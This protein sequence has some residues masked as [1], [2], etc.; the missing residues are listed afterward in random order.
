[1]LAGKQVVVKR[2]NTALAHDI[3]QLDVAVRGDG[4]ELGIGD[5]ARIAKHVRGEGAVRII[6][7]RAL[8]DADARKRIGVF[9]DEGDV[10]LAHVGGHDALALRARALVLDAH[11]HD[12]VRNA[13]HGGK[14]LNHVVIFCDLGVG[15]HR[16]RRAIADEQH[17]IAVVDQSARSRRGHRRVLVLQRLVLILARREHLHAPQLYRQRAEDGT[18]EHAERDESRAQPLA[19]AARRRLGGCGSRSRVFAATRP[20]LVVERGLHAD[21]VDGTHAVAT[22]MRGLRHRTGAARADHEKRPD[23]QC[24]Y[25][26]RDQS[27]DD[28]EQ[29]AHTP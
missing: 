23:G 3:A 22:A 24:R 12:V 13:Q 5:S 8:L 14:A 19:H 6:A 2:L 10:A 28:C 26:E 29:H 18:R 17:A 21:V 4:F 15:E 16:E 27:D 7:H 9:G 11:A 25:D 20:H 1:M